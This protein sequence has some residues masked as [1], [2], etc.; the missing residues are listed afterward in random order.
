MTGGLKNTAWRGK[1]IRPNLNV[2]P[3]ETYVELSLSDIIKNLFFLTHLNVKAHSFNIKAVVSMS[4]EQLFSVFRFK[5]RGLPRYIITDGVY[6]G[7]KLDILEVRF[8]LFLLRA[9]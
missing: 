3:V 1:A 9:G 8:F 6:F 4:T 5:G 7:E 2:R